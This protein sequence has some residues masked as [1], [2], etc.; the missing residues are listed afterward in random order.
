MSRFPTVFAL[1]PWLLTGCAAETTGLS[2]AEPTVAA[3]SQSAS[4]RYQGEASLTLLY[5]RTA[6]GTMSFLCSGTLV[7]LEDRRTQQPGILTAAHCFDDVR[8]GVDGYYASFDDGKRYVKLTRAWIGDRFAG[9][10]IAFIEFETPLPIQ[11]APRLQPS[12]AMP[13]SLAPR[14]ID[15]GEHVWTWGNPDDQGRALAVGYVMNPDYR[16]PPIS[17]KM[18]GKDV[19][20]DMRGYIVV[21][22][23][24]APGSSGG[25]LLSANGIVGV[26]SADFQHERGF[27]TAFVTPVDRL[28]PLLAT[29]GKPL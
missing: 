9:A 19:Q 16:K 4:T 1:L 7:A 3:A 23:N 21:D 14:P 12:A 6:D 10:D 13:L 20:L 27:K 15:A 2:A 11:A 18:Q 29:P 24:T 17:G 8:T 28:A 22:I 5:T 26:F 25:S